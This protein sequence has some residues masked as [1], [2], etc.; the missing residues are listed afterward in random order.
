M[1]NYQIS[2]ESL[3]GTKTEQNLH[4]ALSGE[5]Q[6]HVRYK[7]FEKAA[8]K[9]GF[10]E[11][12]R[13]FCTI[14]ENEKEHAEI[15]FKYLGGLSSTE[16]NLKVAANGEHFEWSDMYATFAREAE[17]EGFHEI[18]ARFKLVAAIEKDHE[19]KYT[20]RLKAIRENTVFSSENDDEA[21]ICLNCGHIHHGKTP[22]PLCPTCRH[23]KGYFKK[24]TEA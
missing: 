7:F 9:D 1:N 10:E 13:L 18:A 17:E 20:A 14:S 8:K 21:W 3:S 15:W 16:E 12:S 19:Q 22:P 2:K 11:I 5:S 4:T 24:G 23:D 6:A